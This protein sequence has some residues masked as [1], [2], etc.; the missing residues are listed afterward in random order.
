MPPEG[1]PPPGGEIAPGGRV[2]GEAEGLPGAGV[3][4]YQ[5]VSNDYLMLLIAL[6]AVG[7]WSVLAGMLYC[8]ETQLLEQPVR[9]K[10]R[11]R[12]ATHGRMS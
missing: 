1:T 12:G 9:S 11:R 6:L 7:G 10:R 4:S 8:R 2:P 5:T 3:G